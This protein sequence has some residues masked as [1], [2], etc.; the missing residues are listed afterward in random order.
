MADREPLDRRQRGPAGGRVET[1]R[2]ALAPGRRA[3]PGQIDDIGGLELL[4]RPREPFVRIGH[5]VGVEQH[6]VGDARAAPRPRRRDRGGTTARSAARTPQPDQRSSRAGQMLGP[7]VDLDRLVHHA[8]AATRRVLVAHNGDRVERVPP[9][10]DR[11]QDRARGV[12]AA[13]PLEPVGDLALPGAVDDDHQV[14]HAGGSERLVRGMPFAQH[15]AECRLDRV[16]IRVALRPDVFAH[17]RRHLRSPSSSA[18]AS[19]GP[20]DPA[21][22]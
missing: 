7:H 5:V 16:R 14:Q 3:Q 13:D 4:L 8:N 22:Y 2:E 12:V 1:R 15:L 11:A 18:S 9:F 6:H 17:S 21:G 20:A 10:L 19:A